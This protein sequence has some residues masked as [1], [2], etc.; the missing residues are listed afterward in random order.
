[1][2]LLLDVYS[3]GEAHIEGA[4]G[5]ALVQAIAENSQKQPIFIEQ[6]EQLFEQLLPQLQDNDIVLTLGAGNIG[7]ISTS[8]LEKLRAMQA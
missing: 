5:Q 1:V 6:H 2:L 7:A 8:L 4:D 3:A